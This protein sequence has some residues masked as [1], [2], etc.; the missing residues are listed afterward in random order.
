MMT[1]EER[2]KRYESELNEVH[3]SVQWGNH[4]YKDQNLFVVIRQ[5]KETLAVFDTE[6]EA[7]EYAMKLNKRTAEYQSHVA[8]REP[9]P[10]S[11]Y[12]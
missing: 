2:K 12:R 8:K 4:G 6:A 10:E 11:Y 3:T 9:I 5:T 7:A 1:R